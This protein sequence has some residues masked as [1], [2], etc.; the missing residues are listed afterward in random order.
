MRIALLV[1]DR[2]ELTPSRAGHFE[3]IDKLRSL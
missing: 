3:F 2:L 1:L